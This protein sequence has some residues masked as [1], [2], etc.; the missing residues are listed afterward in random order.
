MR[1]PMMYPI[2]LTVS[3]VGSVVAPPGV[4]EYSDHQKSNTYQGVLPIWKSEVFVSD[5]NQH[6]DQCAADENT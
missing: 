5:P 4:E 3:I 6:L 1:K 2:R